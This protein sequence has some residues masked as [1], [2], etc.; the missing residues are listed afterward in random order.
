MSMLTI[1]SNGLLTI[2]H[3]WLRTAGGRRAADRARLRSSPARVRDESSEPDEAATSILRN[4][5]KEIDVLNF[6][7]RSAPGATR[8]ERW[9]P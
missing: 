9:R 2:G 8:A 7:P 6:G 4:R 3:P 1:P 5:L